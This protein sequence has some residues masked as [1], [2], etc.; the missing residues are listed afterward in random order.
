[1]EWLAQR[2]FMCCCNYDCENLLYTQLAT[3]GLQTCGSCNMCHVVCFSSPRL[4]YYSD[5]PVTWKRPPV[6]KSQWPILLYVLLQQWQW[7]IYGRP[8]WRSYAVTCGKE[9]KPICTLNLPAMTALYSLLLCEHRMADEAI[10]LLIINGYTQC[11]RNG[12]VFSNTW[13]NIELSV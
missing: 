8:E 9:L 4:Q 6:W 1:M 11:N 5:M 10:M 13:L 2:A 12:A 3:V 7:H